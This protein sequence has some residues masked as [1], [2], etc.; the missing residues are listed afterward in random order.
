MS[1]ATACGWETHTESLAATA[2][3]GSLIADRATFVAGMQVS[4]T[5]AASLLLITALVSLLTCSLRPDVSH[6]P[7]DPGCQG[8][9]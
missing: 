7:E 5:I 9:I 8:P 1:E 4:F 2:V 3:F 6:P